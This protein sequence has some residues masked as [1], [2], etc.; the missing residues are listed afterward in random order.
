MEKGNLYTDRIREARKK[1]EAPQGRTLLMRIQRVALTLALSASGAGL[2]QEDSG[3]EG[4]AGRV[5]FLNRKLEASS[6]YD[7]MELPGNLAER[8]AR[9]SAEWQGPLTV[10]AEDDF[11]RGTSRTRYW[12]E[13]GGERVEVHF[14]DGPAAL[15]SGEIVKVRGI[16]LGNQIAATLTSVSASAAGPSTPPV[17]RR[18]RS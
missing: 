11:A 5:G 16:R 1:M 12:M 18:S 2:C 14:A 7:R 8:V 10:I 9:I 3:S 13:T 6:P 17:S 4:L 15:T